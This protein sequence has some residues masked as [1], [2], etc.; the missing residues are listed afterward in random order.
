V[1]DVMWFIQVMFFSSDL[2][3]KLN[4]YITFLMAEWRS[5]NKPLQMH[6]IVNRHSYFYDK[7]LHNHL[8]T[9]TLTVDQFTKS[10][11]GTTDYSFS[12]NSMA[13]RHYVNVLKKNCK[14]VQVK[15]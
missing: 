8:F 9:F 10:Y 5:S 12:V 1:F 7:P 4:I 2:V 13:I 14:F 15:Y 6:G 11:A 3:K